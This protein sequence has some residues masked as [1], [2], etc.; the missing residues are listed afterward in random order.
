MGLFDKSFKKTPESTTTAGG[1]CPECG[2]MALAFGGRVQCTNPSCKNFISVPAASTHEPSPK[3]GL[4]TPQT[5]LTV[6][7]RNFRGEEKSFLTD[8]AA[9][10]RKQQHYVVRVAPSGERIVL[11]RSRIL[12]LSEVEAAV[13]Q[14]VE[15]GQQWPSARERQ[16]LNYHKKNGS[17]SPLYDK[18]RAKYPKW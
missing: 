12:N 10:E 9:M 14:R 5:P 4:F 8:A 1:Q 11:A 3:R 15:P 7:Y 18:I 17:T 16:V 2:A 13:P 6:R